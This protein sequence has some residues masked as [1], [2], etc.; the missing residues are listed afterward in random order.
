MQ[1]TIDAA[2]SEI[3]QA[4]TVLLNEEFA[5]LSRDPNAGQIASNPDVAQSGSAYKSWS[6]SHC[7]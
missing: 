5:V 1:Q 2:P 7:H 4:V 3:K 6:D